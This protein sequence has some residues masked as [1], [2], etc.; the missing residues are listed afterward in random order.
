MKYPLDSS[1]RRAY[2]IRDLPNGEPGF[3]E[4]NSTLGFF[5]RNSMHAQFHTLVLEKVAEPTPR[6]AIPQAELPNSLAG[7]VS[8]DEI[9]D[10]LRR[11]PSPKAPCRNLRGFVR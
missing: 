4:P 3:I 5:R 1:K 6:D 7:T 9:F 8:D 10:P 2:L 11:E